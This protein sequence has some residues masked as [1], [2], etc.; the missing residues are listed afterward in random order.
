VTIAESKQATRIFKSLVIIAGNAVFESWMRITNS[1][2]LKILVMIFCEALFN[3]GT[4]SKKYFTKPKRHRIIRKF[5]DS[6]RYIFLKKMIPAGISAETMHTTEKISVNILPVLGMG[7][8]VS[9]QPGFLQS[10]DY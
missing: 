4:K 5:N 6:L 2:R 10:L 7:Q 1:K 3:C 8:L 9:A